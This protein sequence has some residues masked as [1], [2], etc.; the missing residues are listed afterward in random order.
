[1]SKYIEIPE[2]KIGKVTNPMINVLLEPNPDG[3]NSLPP[4]T[5]MNGYPSAFLDSIEGT[6]GDDITKVN[7]C[8]MPTPKYIM[9]LD[10]MKE[11]STAIILCGLAMFAFASVR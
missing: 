11:N 4:R 2:I 3:N 7:I 10:W 1:M 5:N 8:G 6:G 9:F